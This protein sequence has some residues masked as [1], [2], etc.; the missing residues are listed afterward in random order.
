MSCLT[1]G[2]SL[3]QSKQNLVCS[4][5]EQRY[6]LLPIEH[7]TIHTP[8]TKDELIAFLQQQIT[9]QLKTISKLQEKI[10]LLQD[11]LCQ[12]TK[13]EHI[14]FK[15]L[16]KKL[17]GIEQIIYQTIV[18]LSMRLNKPLTYEQIIKTVRAKV[19]FPI[20]TETIT[21]CVRRLREQDLIFSPRKGLFY[22]KR[23]E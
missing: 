9:S 3:A 8:R 2:E 13:E 11:T 10:S 16:E 22:P 5:C 18:D 19:T 20:K 1:C 17:K 4:R 12:R 23:R 14:E 7:K 15:E 21:R 6:I